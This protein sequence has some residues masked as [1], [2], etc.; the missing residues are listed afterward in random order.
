MVN[1]KWMGCL[2]VLLMFG[3]AACSKKLTPPEIA[4]SNASS[5]SGISGDVSGDGSSPS[6]ALEGSAG[7]GF[8]EENLTES[9]VPSGPPI[10]T[11]SNGSNGD[12]GFGSTGSSGGSGSDSASSGGSG[13][14]M[15][16]ADEGIQ[17][18]RLLPFS[19][20]DD[21]KDVH[22]QFDKYDLDSRS[23]EVLRQNAAYLKGHPNMK[24]EIQGHADERG[25]NNYNI[26]LGQRRAT[27][28]KRYL[29]SLGIEG[30][31]IHIISYGEEKP[32]CLESNESCWWQN[33]RAH[34]LSS[35]K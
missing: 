17:E 3:A 35:G 27:S 18:A 9:G 33:R 29:M 1:K 21:L 10:I 2:I 12:S 24:I 5:E 6:S 23:E 22:F 15:G 31:R 14:G 34:F 25:T 30:D 28:T 20:S 19:S 8:T 32:F 26:A 4:A 13:N 11:G 16:G 7:E